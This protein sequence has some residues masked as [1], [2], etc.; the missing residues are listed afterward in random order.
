MLRLDKVPS[1]SSLTDCVV[2]A[3]P[4]PS[5]NPHHFTCSSLPTTQETADAHKA[6]GFPAQLPSRTTRT[7]QVPPHPKAAT[8]H[9][10][11]TGRAPALPSCRHHSHTRGCGRLCGRGTGPTAAGAPPWPAGRRRDH[12][13]HKRHGHPTVQTVASTRWTLSPWS[14]RANSSPRHPLTTAPRPYRIFIHAPPP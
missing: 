2:D 3:I 14:S 9:F 5:L 7:V 4:S 12:Q 13:Y 6:D 11:T 10:G 8:R 1:P